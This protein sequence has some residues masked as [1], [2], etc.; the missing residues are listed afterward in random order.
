VEDINCTSPSASSS[1]RSGK[2]IF[3]MPC[4]WNLIYIH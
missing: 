4:L 2:V 3:H 1:V